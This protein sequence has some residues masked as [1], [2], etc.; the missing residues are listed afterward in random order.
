MKKYCWLL[1]F[2]LFLVGCNS[3]LVI[4]STISVEGEELPTIGYVGS[5]AEPDG[6]NPPEIYKMLEPVRVNPNAVVA[7]DYHDT[8]KKV[9]VKSWHNGELIEDYRKLDQYKIQVPSDEGIYVFSIATRWNFRVAG[10]TVFVV[11]V[12]DN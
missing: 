12:K 1:F 6:D 8:P 3:T 4:S 2:L 9:L 10:N 5:N 7:I 11:E